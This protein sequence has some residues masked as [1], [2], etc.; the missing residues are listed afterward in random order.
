NRREAHGGFFVAGDLHVKQPRINPHYR[1]RAARAQSSVLN[2]TDSRTFSSY[3]HE[4]YC[5]LLN[6]EV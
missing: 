5:V 4:T 1:V 3:S 2:P 6:F